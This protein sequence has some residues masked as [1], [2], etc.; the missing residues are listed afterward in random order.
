MSGVS[1]R[2]LQPAIDGALA[3]LQVLDGETRTI[4]SDDPVMS[5]SAFQAMTQAQTYCNRKLVF[6][7]YVERHE[8]VEAEIKV[9]ETPLVTVNAVVIKSVVGDDVLLVEGDDYVVERNRIRFLDSLTLDNF[10]TGADTLG[11][12]ILHR[13]VEVDYDGGFKTLKN[14]GSLPGGEQANVDALHQGLVQQAAANYRR[15]TSVGL[16]VI[17]GGST[18]GQITQTQQAGGAGGLTSSAK[19]MLAPLIYEGMAFDA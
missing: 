2:W 6:A 5:A 15:N 16:Q 10:V 18:T 4:K 9:R 7:N 14:A 3:Y 12:S 13:V 1:Q 8:D 11:S 19:E 17:T